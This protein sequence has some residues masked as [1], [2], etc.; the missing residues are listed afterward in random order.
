MTKAE[1]FKVLKD[2]SDDEEILLDLECDINCITR[3]DIVILATTI[4]SFSLSNH[5]VL[6]FSSWHCDLFRS[7]PADFTNWIHRLNDDKDLDQLLIE[8]EAAV[9]GGAL[10]RDQQKAMTKIVWNEIGRRRRLSGHPDA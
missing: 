7:D 3:D 8:A 2:V 9:P 6:Y 10:T 1:L 4:D 5:Q